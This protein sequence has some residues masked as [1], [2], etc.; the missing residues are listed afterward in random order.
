MLLTVVDVP[1]V[2][3]TAVEAVLLAVAD[4][5]AVGTV[6]LAVFDVAVGVAITVDDSSLGLLTSCSALFEIDKVCNDA[7]TGAGVV[8]D[9]TGLGNSA[10][11][12]DSDGNAD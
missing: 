3:V 8:N 10:D 9:V 5:T 1:A 7:A 2:D 6:L 12:V 4:V 11:F